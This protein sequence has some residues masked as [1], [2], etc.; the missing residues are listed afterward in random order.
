MTDTTSFQNHL[1]YHFKNSS[2]LEEAFLAPGAS[3][4]QPDVVGP[5]KGNKRLALVGDAALRLAVIDEWYKDN[6][7]PGELSK[8][9]SPFSD[10][11]V[12]ASGQKRFVEVG[13]NNHLE[14]LATRWG[15]EK[16]IVENP[17][18]KGQYPKETL[19]AT[20]EAIIGAVWVDSDKDLA[21]V[22]K[23]LNTLNT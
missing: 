14:Q 12:L 19:A 13:T 23:V 22:Q 2:L 17:L 20:V 11:H 7:E 4:S 15:M 5:E 16:L 1:D 21:A 18:Q 10:L 6:T 3:V 9:K 8:R